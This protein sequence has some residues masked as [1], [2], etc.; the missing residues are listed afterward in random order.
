M[1]EQKPEKQKTCSEPGCDRKLTKE[2][3]TICEHC[4]ETARASLFHRCGVKK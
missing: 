3:T 2:H 1:T 4:L